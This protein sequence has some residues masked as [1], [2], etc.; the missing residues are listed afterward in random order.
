MG[1]TNQ[2][3]SGL[4]IHNAGNND[5][6]KITPTSPGILEIDILFTHAQ[7]DLDL[8]LV[9][10]NGAE[11]KL[12]STTNDNEHMSWTVTA[13]GQSY[14]IHVAGFQN[15]TNPNYTLRVT[16]MRDSVA[17]IPSTLL[18]SHPTHGPRPL[19]R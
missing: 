7:G 10:A 18:T 16:G 3:I 12:A 5:W 8:R 17:P 2:L 13:A 15:A 4:T 1:S 6:F 9:H 11:A 19:T 14:F